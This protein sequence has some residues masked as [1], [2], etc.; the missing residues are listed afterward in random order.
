MQIEANGE[1]F[2][3]FINGSYLI[4]MEDGGYEDGDILLVA[5]RPDGTEMFEVGFDNFNVYQYPNL[6]N[7]SE[8]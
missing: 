2:R 6:P 8:E 5:I 7:L 3:F 1:M 4:N